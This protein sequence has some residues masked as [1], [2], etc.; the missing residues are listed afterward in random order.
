MSRL[1]IKSDNGWFAATAGLAGRCGETLRRGLQAVRS[2][3][4]GR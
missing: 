4:A 3:L 2:H 1:K